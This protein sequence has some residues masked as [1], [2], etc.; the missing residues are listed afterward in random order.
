LGRRLQQNR[1]RGHAVQAI[2]VRNL[3][4]FRWL[5]L[6]ETRAKRSKRLFCESLDGCTSEGGP[7]RDALGCEDS[8]ERLSVGA[9]FSLTVWASNRRTKFKKL[10]GS[11]MKVLWVPHTA[12]YY[13]LSI[14][15]PVP[16]QVL[17]FLCN[18]PRRGNSWLDGKTLPLRF[19]VG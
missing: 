4:S 10:S 12:A 11:E 2:P 1:A 17:L 6:G 3:L 5:A 7:G 18:L 19:A 9:S 16:V 8:V 14:Q 15:C 13:V